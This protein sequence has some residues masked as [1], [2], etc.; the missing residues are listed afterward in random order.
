VLVGFRVSLF[1]ERQ[2]NR[3]KR[4]WSVAFCREIFPIGSVF[5]GLALVGACAPKVSAGEWQCPSDGGASDDGTS[6]PSLTDP[7][8]VPWSTGFEPAEQQAPLALGQPQFANFCD[9]L[10]AGGYCYGDEPYTPVTEP[11]HGGRFSAEFKVVD[12]KE[13]QTRCVRQGILP[14]SAYYGAWYFIPEPLKDVRSAWN[15]WHFKGRDTPLEPLH[16]LWDV[17]LA[18]GQAE[19][20]ELVVYDRLAPPN[21][22]TYRSEDYKRVPIGSWFHIELFLKR[23]SDATG[24]IRLYQDGTLLFERVNLKSDASKFSQ[25]YVGN[26]ADGAT[27][28]D[29]SLYVDDVSISATLSATQ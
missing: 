13:N 17:T 4:C 10:K 2:L 16:D 12:D 18:K 21:N 14:A 11:H 23:A 27:P 24:E 1:R 29:S 9:Y 19:D 25:W 8:T 20:W 28:P 3:R 26:W 22:S 5:A 15:L 7:L 6:P